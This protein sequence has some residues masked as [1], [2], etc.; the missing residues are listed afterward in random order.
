MCREVKIL[1]L[2]AKTICVGELFEENIL[3]DSFCVYLLWV[4]LWICIRMAS[5]EA[6]R[7]SEDSRR[8]LKGFNANTNM[9]IMLCSRH[10]HNI[11]TWW[12]FRTVDKLNH[13]T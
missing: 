4:P 8:S 2:I 3:K 5:A 9:E 6:R 7:F 12:R 11:G 1:T 10:H 13:M